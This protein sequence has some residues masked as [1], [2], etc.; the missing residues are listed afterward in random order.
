MSSATPVEPTASSL[1]YRSSNFATPEFSQETQTLTSSLA[2]P[3]Q[4]N[5][6][7]SYWA[8]LLPRIFSNATLRLVA[9]STVPSLGAA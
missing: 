7:A 8:A 2:L 3:I 4:V 1:V 9:P 5:F 6:E